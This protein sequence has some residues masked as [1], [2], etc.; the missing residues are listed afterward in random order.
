M[1]PRIDDAQMRI[2][3]S[4]I[5]NSRTTPGAPAA[6]KSVDISPADRDHIGAE[7]WRHAAGYVLSCVRPRAEKLNAPPHPGPNGSKPPQLDL[8]KTLI[9]F[10]VLIDPGKNIIR[11]YMVAVT[12]TLFGEC[13]LRRERGHIGSLGTVRSRKLRDERSAGR[14]TLH[15]TAGATQL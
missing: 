12:P 6:A 15:P 5:P 3:S 1:E 10:L 14:A 8:S 7:Y 2:P 9:V 4:R 13:S 11:L